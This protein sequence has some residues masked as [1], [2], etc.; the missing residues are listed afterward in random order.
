MIV[1]GDK[2]RLLDTAIGPPID[3]C[4]SR[5]YSPVVI[6]D[7]LRLIMWKHI[8]N[9]IREL[10]SKAIDVRYVSVPVWKPWRDFQR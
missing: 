4:N 7:V 8:F 2:Y 6:A 9:K 3:V 5:R 1:V 10:L